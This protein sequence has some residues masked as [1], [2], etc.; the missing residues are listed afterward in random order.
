[1]ASVLQIGNN[2]RAQIRK[3]GLPALCKSFK[4]KEDAERWTRRYEGILDGDEPFSGAEPLTDLEESHILAISRPCERVWGVYF[5][6]SARK[7]MY[8]GSSRDVDRR[9]YDHVRDGRRFDRYTVIQCSCEERMLALEKHYIQKL[10]PL[11]N[12]LHVVGRTEAKPC[13]TNGA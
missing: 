2:W 11:W 9:I 1:M 3:A 13:S 8:V 7:I 6:V 5:L 12:V 10:S 4:N